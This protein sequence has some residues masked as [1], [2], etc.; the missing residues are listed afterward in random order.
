MSQDQKNPKGEAIG[1]PFVMNS[2]EVFARKA[3]IDEKTA[4]GTQLFQMM[5]SFYAGFASALDVFEGIKSQPTPKLYEQ[6]IRVEL[7]KF[8]DNSKALMQ[9]MGVPT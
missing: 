8:S 1:P 4:T 5:Q 7:Q 2:W 9:S 3:G 6:I